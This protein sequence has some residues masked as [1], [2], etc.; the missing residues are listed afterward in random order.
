[1]SGGQ[2]AGKGPPFVVPEQDFSTAEGAVAALQSPNLATRYVAYTALQKFGPAAEPALATLSKSE[3]SRFRARALWLLCKLGLPQERV[4]TLLKLALRD[5]STD[6]RCAAIRIAR[7]L[8][9]VTTPVL[10]EVFRNQESSPAVQREYL[11]ALRE[12]KDKRCAQAWA[13]LAAFGD[14]SDRWFLEALGIAAD[15]RWDEVL[16]L[17]QPYFSQLGS[18]KVRNLV[19][20]SR[21]AETPALLAKLVSDKQ[22]PE[23]ELPR[24]FRAFDFQ[25]DSPA[26]SAALT[27]LAFTPPSRGDQTQFIQAE[28]LQRLEGFD[29]SA[30][31]EYLAA[32]NSVLDASGDSEQFV[33]LVGKFNV[34]D[35]YDDLLALAR[36]H[37]NDQLAIEAIRTL[38]DKDQLALI[39]DSIYGDDATT[40]DETLAAL[41]TAADPRSADL[42][43]ATVADA[44][45]TQSV[46]RSAIRALGSIR[47]GAQ[48]LAKL[49]ESGEYDPLLKD[50]LAATLH[51]VKWK[52]IKEQTLALFPLPPGRDSEPVPPLAE[53][54]ER[55]GDVTRGRIAF[56]AT[57]TCAKC[58]LVNGLGLNIGPD[59]SEIGKKLSKQALFES[60]LYPSAAISHNYETWAVLDTNGNIT[61]GLLVS[62]TPDEIQIKDEKAL[63]R[64]IKVADVEERRRLEISLMPADL[65]KILSVQELIDIVAF[66]TTLQQAQ[67]AATN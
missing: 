48:S 64:T 42:L 20:R 8:P 5:N 56:H 24:L 32:L 27:A 2:G 52:D 41:G 29:L 47:A 67:S 30:K 21:G 35:R 34:S 18:D 51:T 46:R 61:T 54:L 31:P 50:A 25:A 26:K 14:D 57:G 16:E 59:L 19:W 65:N 36:R 17:A 23:A 43:L 63:V 11:I 9:D 53:L 3:N 33:R 4:V 12:S 10:E 44:E 60:V 6:V 15:G 22:T 45:R 49:A 1:G 38:M 28:A 55:E 39:R 7:Q 37:A 58:H 40:A 62:A 66:M 13:I